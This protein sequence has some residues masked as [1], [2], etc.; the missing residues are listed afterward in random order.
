[1]L[2]SRVDTLYRSGAPAGQKRFVDVGDLKREDQA[3]VLELI[4]ELKK[5]VDKSK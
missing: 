3:K 2:L 5:E 4:E 1:M